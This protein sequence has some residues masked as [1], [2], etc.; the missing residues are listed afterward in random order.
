MGKRKLFSLVIE[1]MTFNFYS[2]PFAK[3]RKN[4][5]SLTYIHFLIYFLPCWV[6]FNF[7]QR[8]FLQLAQ[9]T[10]LNSPA[11]AAVGIANYLFVKW[12]RE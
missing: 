10:T 5:K 7:N 8:V 1:F 9:Q 4:S 11:A 6:H 3:D 2:L 12:I